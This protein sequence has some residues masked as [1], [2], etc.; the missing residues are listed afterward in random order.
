MFGNVELYY[1]R[2]LLKKKGLEDL[3]TIKTLGVEDMLRKKAL[4]WW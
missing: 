3:S 4:V 1:N 2:I